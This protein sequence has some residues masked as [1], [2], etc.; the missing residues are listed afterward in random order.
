[1]PQCIESIVREEG[2]SSGPFRGGKKKRGEGSPTTREFESHGRIRK[3]RA[4][5]V[6]WSGGGRGYLEKE[7]MVLGGS[8]R[9]CGGA[10]K[11]ATKAPWGGRGGLGDVVLIG[12]T[13]C[14]RVSGGGGI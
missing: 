3:L 8:C 7:K 13:A 9:F 10:P 1:V 2:A 6:S 4:Q 12:C 5:E 14:T 11:T